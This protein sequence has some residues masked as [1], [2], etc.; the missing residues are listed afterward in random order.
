MDTW[1][2][3][4]TTSVLGAVALVA[5][6]LAG[7]QIAVGAVL[8][9]GALAD[10]VPRTSLSPYSDGAFTVRAAAVDSRVDIAGAEDGSYVLGHTPAGSDVV[11]DLDLLS[12]DTAR[13]WWVQPATGTTL[14]L[15][16]LS[17]SGIAR[18]PVPQGTG[19]SADWVLVVD[20]VAAGY[21]AP[22][23]D[24]IARAVGE[25]VRA[26][27]AE[28]GSGADPD[29]AGS[30]GGS[31]SGSD[32]GSGDGPDGGGSDGPDPSGSRSG[33]SG[34]DD[35]ASRGSGSNGSGP[36]GSGSDGGV[37]DP[38]GSGQRSGGSAGDGPASGS[39]PEDRDF[40][41]S[42][43]SGRSRDDDGSSEG[44]SGTDGSGSGRDDSGGDKP[45]G[46]KPGGDKTGGDDKSGGE[47]SGGDGSGGNEASGAKDSG[48]ED[49]GTED[50]GT[51]DSGTED[52]GA[53]GGG[54]D[55]GT[56]APRAPA[57]RAPAPEREE[58]KEPT[59]SSSAKAADGTWDRLAQ[60]ESSGDWAISTG[61][62]YH[63]GLQFDKGTWSDFGGTK[64]AP[65]ADGA[66]KEQQI[67]IA[68]KVRDARG[69]YGSWP[70]C[71]NKLGLPR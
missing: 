7:G 12:G 62:G 13:P 36:G 46:D 68:T 10:A 37:A 24:A 15:A 31:D 30:G 16:Q 20:D 18:F 3:R 48:T 2:S 34:S 47:K 52:S 35:S 32:S 22:D 53:E 19:G 4:R 8:E 70:A 33:R 17:S 67:E 44:G 25:R 11:L 50:S 64:Y 43:D 41:G 57:P 51:E 27:V 1:F 6:T 28:A 40:G 39:E 61:N 45:S 59:P 69:G 55:S 65:T 29:R 66:T 60:C 5:G 9:R 54:G 71:A 21:G 58:K 26:A 56:P 49:S 63:G 14:E 38:G 23:A 42:G